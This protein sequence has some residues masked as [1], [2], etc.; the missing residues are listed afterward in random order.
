MILATGY[1]PVL[2]E[3]L[4][5]KMQFSDASYY[6]ES[7]C[8]WDIGPNGLRGW[9]LRDVSE[10]PNGRQVAGHP[11]LYL[12]GVFYKGRGAFYNMGIEAAIAAEEIK[13]Q[14]SRRL[15]SAAAV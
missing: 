8:D 7:G 6:P 12:V 3:Y 1:R 2:H 4:D 11:G 14:L 15:F 13:T 10:R 5:I 9:P